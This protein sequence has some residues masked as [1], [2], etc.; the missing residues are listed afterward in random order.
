MIDMDGA[1][2]QVVIRGQADVAIARMSARSLARREGM[3]EPATEALVIAV[4]EIAQNI[5]THGGGG[6]VAIA[7]VSE[8]GR[9]G[10]VVIARDA[11]PGIADA[12]RA[13]EDGYSTAGTLGLGLA[14][15]RRLTD[16]FEVR[17]SPG[18]GTTVVMK[19]WRP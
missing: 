17:S 1:E 12:E 16:E 3:G 10:L 9:R 5:A 4:S 7:A 18:G 11:G 15:A 19:K 13:M 2:V 6:E 8:R 14:S